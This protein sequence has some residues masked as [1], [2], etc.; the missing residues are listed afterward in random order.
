MA[1]IVLV[2]LESKKMGR[3][4]GREREMWFYGKRR[5][6]GGGAAHVMLFEREKGGLFLG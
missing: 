2:F 3:E 1:A 4:R 6:G 5:R